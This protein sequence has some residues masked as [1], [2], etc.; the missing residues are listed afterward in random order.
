MKKMFKPFVAVFA[1]LSVFFLAI[2][3]PM[4]FTASAAGVPIAGNYLSNGQVLVGSTGAAPVAATL[5]GTAGQVT[6]TN[7]AGTITLST[8]QSIA[9]TSSPTFKDLTITYGVAAAT[10]VISGAAEAATMNTGQGA[11]E[12]YAMDQDVLTTSTPAFSGATMTGGLALYSR[13]E[14]QILAIEAA[15]AGELYFCSDCTTTT[16]CVSTGTAAADMAA[17]EDPSAACD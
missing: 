4:L 16:V 17:I 15:A 2:S 12:L 13:T 3:F 8:P 11:Y 10:A 9:T 5:T 14:A 1:F 6:V 7:G